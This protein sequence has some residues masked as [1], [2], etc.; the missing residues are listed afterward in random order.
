MSRMSDLT[1][2]KVLLY[3][4]LIPSI[5]LIA[6]YASN[7]IGERWFSTKGTPIVIKTET[8]A[9]IQGQM[10]GSPQPGRTVIILPDPGLDRA[11]NSRAVKS[12]TGDELA[13]AILALRPDVAV[14]RYDQR[15]TGR[16]PGD[17]RMTSLDML[18]ND[19][20]AFAAKATGKTTIIAHGDSCAT[21]LY[22]RRQ[23]KV[24]QWILVSC[25][26]SGTLLE[27][28]AQRFFQN[29]ENS[30]VDQK[31]ISRCK[32]EWAD[33]N[34]ALDLILSARE[35]PAVI[36]AQDGDSPDLLVFRE[37]LRE[38]AW[39]RREWTRQAAGFKVLASMQEIK[40][41]SI[42][43]PEYDLVMPASDRAAMSRSKVGPLIRPLPQSEFFLLQTDKPHR[44]LVERVMFFKSP[45]TR[46]NAAAIQ[47][48]ASSIQ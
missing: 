11:F 23:L 4:T 40:N 46:V 15:G 24:D 29:M 3:L 36:P 19:L 33:W 48:I 16:S 17:S 2:A 22:A 30:G 7:F 42:F 28:W 44:A 1:R 37:A 47:T 32:S 8:G 38:L 35:R 31:T 43:W 20:V 41:V 13:G 34:A 14:I 10:E 25:A 18:R 5:L 12:N 27:N 26:Y 45:F 39:E 21:A 9:E 6:V